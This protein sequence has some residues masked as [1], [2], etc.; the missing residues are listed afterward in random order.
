[1]NAVLPQQMRAEVVEPAPADM[2]ADT[3]VANL[4]HSE[5]T[6]HG[7]RPITEPGQLV[8]W[9]VLGHVAPTSA[10]LYGA[11]TSVPQPRSRSRWMVHRRS[12]AC[13]ARSGGLAR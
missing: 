5:L 11:L 10:C 4:E 7:T 3:V 2:A 6:E 9:N 8:S 12:H 1:M 13:R